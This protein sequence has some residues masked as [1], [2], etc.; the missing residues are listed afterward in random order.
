MTISHE[1]D[2]NT[3]LIILCCE[4]KTEKAYFEIIAD[5]F[6][7]HAVHTLHIIGGKGQHKVLT[8]SF[9]SANFKIAQRNRKTC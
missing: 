6:R 4:G 7:V 2:L 5:T 1:S 3:R 9:Q 8:E